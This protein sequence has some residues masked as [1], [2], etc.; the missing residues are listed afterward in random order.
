MQLT[1]PA[2]EGSWLAERF[3]VTQPL[4]NDGYTTRYRAIDQT[5]GAELLLLE[6]TPPGSLR[7]PDGSLDTTHLNHDVAHHLRWGWVT[8]AQRL[9]AHWAPG[10][11]VP[12][13]WEVT[14]YTA[15]VGYQVSKNWKSLPAFGRLTVSQAR[16]EALRLLSGIDTLHQQGE[17][18]GWIDPNAIFL[19]HE[20]QASILLTG[21]NQCWWVQ[22]TQTDLPEFMAP[23]LITLDFPAGPS[24]DLYALAATLW[25]GLTGR[26]PGTDPHSRQLFSEGID[27]DRPLVDFLLQSLQADPQRRPDSARS[28]LA[29]LSAQRPPA[30]EA[31]TLDQ[32][33]TR[34]KAHRALRPKKLEC[35]GCQRTLEFVSPAP[36]ETSLNGEGPIHLLKLNL[37]RCASCR[38][39]VLQKVE[40]RS[41]LRICPTCKTGW[42]WPGSSQPGW[43]KKGFHCETCEAE[44]FTRGDLVTVVETDELTTWQDLRLRSGRAEEAWCC[45]R[46]SA[47]FDVT[48]KGTWRLMH[49]SRNPTGYAELWPMEWARVAEGLHPGHGNAHGPSPTEE[50]FL[51]PGGLTLLHG[52]PREWV[53]SYIP[54]EAARWIAGGKIDGKSGLRCRTCLLSLGY[55]DHETLRLVQAGNGTHSETLERY[56]G[57]SFLLNEWHFI[58]KGLPLPDQTHLL[59]HLLDEAVTRAW[60]HGEITTDPI[61]EGKAIDYEGRKGVI[62]VHKG[63]IAFKARLY[64]WTAKWEQLTKAF[65]VGHSQLVCE[66][67]DKQRNG[68][69][70]EPTE[71]SVTLQSGWRGVPIRARDLADRCTLEIGRVQSKVTR[72]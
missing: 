33:D 42:L 2:P 31:P 71:I 38:V 5:N 41:P 63:G 24:S 40:N 18:V 58:A 51:E 12:K 61:Y 70:L 62:T 20:G 66:R 59:E 34:L 7:Q 57:Q 4:T 1:P 49:P 10:L 17:R 26:S 44:F 35:P 60:L 11:L 19:D 16:A 25:F 54:E 48:P 21:V 72:R 9:R 50:Y 43:S 15:Y 29:T 30:A 14:P 13:S 39:G 45:D 64:R 69:E 6:W 53:G 27:F 56:Y 68:F 32:L 8:G 55:S 52:E 28:A 47:Q 65:A 3:L 46:C 22:K 36:R 67:A 37:Q 23:E